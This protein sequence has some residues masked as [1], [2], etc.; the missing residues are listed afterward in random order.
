[1]VAK[2]NVFIIIV[3]LPWKSGK[4]NPEKLTILSTT[5]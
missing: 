2:A 3:H 4:E 5:Q 1:M